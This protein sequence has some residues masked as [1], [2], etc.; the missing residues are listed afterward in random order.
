MAELSPTQLQ[1]IAQKVKELLS[2]ESQG[3]GEVPVV[4][5]LDLIFSLPALKRDGSTE[6]VVEAPLSLLRVSLQKTKTGLQ[7]RQGDAGEWQPLVSLE[8]ISGENPEFQTSDVG[9]EW[10]YAGIPDDPWKLLVSIDALKLK[11]TDLTAE[12]KEEIRGYSSYQLWQQ[13]PGNENK[14]YD[15]YKAYLKL[16][17]TEAA[18]RCNTNEDSRVAEENKRV[19]A[20][21][22]RVS[23][24]EQ[25]QQNETTRQ[26]NEKV[27][28]QKAQEFATN[29]NQRIANDKT[30]SDNE[31]KRVSKETARE[32]SEQNRQK[33]EVARQSTFE[34]NI[35]DS[36]LATSNAVRATEECQDMTSRCSSTNN[37]A[38]EKITTMDNMM[39]TFSVGT[40]SAP[41]K[42]EVKTLRS[43]SIRNIAPLKIESRLYPSYVIQNII[44]Q[45]E[46]DSVSIRPDGSLKVNRLGTTS[47]FVIPTQNTPLFQ[48][49]DITVRNPV[50]RLTSDGKFRLHGN[51][52]RVH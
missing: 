26:N 39:K 18:D 42:L 29:E 33:A 35:N 8:E 51:K 10:K 32:T 40:L 16:E 22:I 38:E 4:T 24:D 15:D 52:I 23:N 19:S 31:T 36:S 13:E 44:Y 2:A 45:R 27:R 25:H 43:I 28:E 7:W 3:V 11:F 34:K 41:I 30:R 48:Q 46:G 37:L 47:V 20:E 17:V 12:Q 1:E 49:V 21:D 50:I 5:T 14:T 9:I 6:S